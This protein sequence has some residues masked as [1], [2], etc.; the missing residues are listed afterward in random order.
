MH[1]PGGRR[2]RNAP[3]RAAGPCDPR[4]EHLQHPASSCFTS[5]AAVARSDSSLGGRKSP[6]LPDVVIAPRS[7]ACCLHG[8]TCA[9]VFFP[10]GT[11]CGAGSLPTSYQPF[12]HIETCLYWHHQEPPESP[13]RDVPPQRL[14]KIPCG[15]EIAD[16]TGAG[17]RQTAN[18][19]GLRLALKACSHPIVSC[20]RERAA[21]VARRAGASPIPR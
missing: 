21:Y 15:F 20:V 10:H 2:K 16:L 14:L 17:A 1:Q 18:V 7:P 5:R 6:S 19:V 8:A 11:R 13:G 4:E 9:T 12:L 3:I